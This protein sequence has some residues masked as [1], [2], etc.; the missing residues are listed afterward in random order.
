MHPDCMDDNFHILGVVHHPGDLNLL[1]MI[2]Q[3]YTIFHQWWQKM[4]WNS[5]GRKNNNYLKH[6]W[7]LPCVCFFFS[8][9][10]WRNIINNIKIFLEY[11]LFSKLKTR[12]QFLMCS[13]ENGHLL[14]HIL[15]TIHTTQPSQNRNLVEIGVKFE[16]CLKH[17]ET[18]TYKI[19]NFCSCTCDLSPH[20]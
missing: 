13:L 9:L 6:L 8:M 4:W 7:K 3:K 19:G 12:N 11:V 17:I 20:W 14:A 18:T 5:H 15:V 1:G 2:G 10:E 16:K